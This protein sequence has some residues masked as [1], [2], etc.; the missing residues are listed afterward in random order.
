MQHGHAGASSDFKKWGVSHHSNAKMDEGAESRARSQ[1]RER[2]VD[3]PEAV[4]GTLIL[5][6]GNRLCFAC[7]RIGKV[8][9]KRR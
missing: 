2:Q 1:G 7:A 8:G 5:R 4:E 9:R 3:G 6:K